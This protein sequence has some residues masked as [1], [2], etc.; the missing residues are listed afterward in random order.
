MA[1]DTTRAWGWRVYGLGVIH[2]ALVALVIGTFLPG[3]SVPK[4]FPAQTM[5]AY[6]AAILMLAAGLALE[7]RRAA[8]WA[9]AVLTAY[10][11]VVVVLL[12]DARLVVAHF[13]LYLVYEQIAEQLAIAAGAL[14]IWASFADIDARLA[15]GLSRAGQVAFGLCAIVFGGAHFAYMELT[16]PLVPKWLPPS[17]LF[18]GYA[19]GVF[20]I[21]GGLAI[22]AGVQARL[23]AVLLAVMYA[24][25]APLVHLPAI[26]AH[27][28][29][30]GAWVENAANLVLVGVAWVVADAVAKPRPDAVFQAA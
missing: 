4:G 13:N 21:A 26:L 2:L 9:A 17:Q 16:A 24:L 3:Q 5:L 6:A 10:F 12:M 15:R 30:A 28:G 20:H 1:A 14:I 27:P 22:V 25:F 19:T 29:D 8:Q 11:G 18:W 23:A 7:W